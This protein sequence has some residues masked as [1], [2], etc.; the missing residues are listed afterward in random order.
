M[1]SQKEREIL[2]ELAKLQLETAHSE[3]NK[4][5]VALWKRH[6]ALRG[7][8]PVIHI[9]LDTFERELLEPKLRCTDPL[10]RRLERDLYRAFFNLTELDD[11]WVV[12]DY[13]AV[14]QE[15]YFFPFGYEITRTSASN[16]GEGAV[17]HRFNYVVEDLGSDFEKLGASRF[18]VRREEALAYQQ[19]AQEVFGDILPARVT[20]GCLGAVPTQQVVHLMGMEAMCYAMYDDPELF[21]QMMDRLA[22]DYISFFRE[23]ERQG[24]LLPTTGFERLNQGT[25]CF[26]DELP[27]HGPLTTRQVWGFMDS[28]ESVSI[29]PQQFGTFMFPCYQKIGALFGLLSYGCCEPVSAVWEYV[30][31]FENLRKVSVSPWC[32]EAFMAEQLRNSSVIYQRKPSPNYL[33]VGK[34]LDEEAFRAHIRTTL[35]TAAGC[36]LEITQRD[37][38]TVNGDIDKVRRYVQIIREEIV[39]HWNA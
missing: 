19:A 14:E 9:E 37:V 27:S 21:L 31:Q 4:A 18:G 34:T 16:A 20:M 11:D 25:K 32:D 8:R 15:T 29:S 2:R 39:S 30:K 7:E 10:A 23:M 12:P 26:T 13:F 28:Q 35:Q 33:G 22:E 38:Y 1:I 3:K 24:L 17:G 36:R 6:N 5:R